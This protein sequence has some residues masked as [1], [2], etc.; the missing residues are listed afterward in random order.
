MLQKTLINDPILL[1]KILDIQKQ[2]IKYK[3]YQDRLQETK[4][5]IIELN[6][7]L[8]NICKQIDDYNKLLPQARALLCQLEA[9]LIKTITEPITGPIAQEIERRFTPLPPGA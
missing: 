2:C 3:A 8:N 7:K 5:R 9:E 4:D 1:Q 6:Q